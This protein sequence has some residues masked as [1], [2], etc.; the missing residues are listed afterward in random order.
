MKIESNVSI[1][2][3]KQPHID[4]DTTRDKVV[5][6]SFV[7]NQLAK[8]VV[9]VNI[10]WFE[11]FRCIS[12]SIEYRQLRW[13]RISH[14]ERCEQQQNCLWSKWEAS[15]HT[16][17]WEEISEKFFNGLTLHIRS[18]AY[19][20]HVGSNWEVEAQISLKCEAAKLSCEL[21]LSKS[22]GHN[23]K[24]HK[25]LTQLNFPLSCHLWN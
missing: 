18:R 25:F 20:L 13:V 2:C 5:I 10:S 17:K 19:C 11:W 1:W 15:L 4:T 22:L 12:L 23:Y 3:S 21:W 8:F 16:C 7:T 9:W 24:S 6:T 14:W